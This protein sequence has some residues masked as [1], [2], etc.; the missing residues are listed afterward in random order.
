MQTHVH[1]WYPVLTPGPNPT[2]VSAPLQAFSRPG[3]SFTPTQRTLEINPRH[4]LIVALKDKL[5]AATEETV[6]ESAV[7]TARLLYETAL[8]ESG[9]VPDDAKAFSQRMYG[10]L[11]DTLGV[12]SLEVALEA[13]E[14]AEPEEAEEKAEETEEKAEETEEKKE[15]AEEKDEL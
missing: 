6:E 4:P 14:A 5:A 1:A 11:K 15:E 12:D 2:T 7:A 13:E 10:V 9:F 3:S 8:L